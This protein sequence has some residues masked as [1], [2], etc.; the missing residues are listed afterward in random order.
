MNL[1]RLLNFTRSARHRWDAAPRR[2]YGTGAPK[3]WWNKRHYGETGGGHHKDRPT[4]EQNERRIQ[5]SKTLSYILRHGAKAAGLSIRSDGFVCVKDL[6]NT[7]ELRHLDFRLLEKIVKM[8]NK[9]RFTLLYKPAAKDTSNQLG[10]WWIRANQGH[11][12][13]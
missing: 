10:S 8:D 2:E 6:L 3:A 4:L 1:T 13:D 11:S 7:A 9:R 5:T 12:I